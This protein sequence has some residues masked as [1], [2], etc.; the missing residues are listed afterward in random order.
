M[1][2]I[3]IRVIS[4][5]CQDLGPSILYL[6]LPVVLSALFYSHLASFHQLGYWNFREGQF[7]GKVFLV[8]PP[9]HPLPMEDVWGCSSV[10]SFVK[11]HPQT[12]FDLIGT[13]LVQDPSNSGQTSDDT[14]LK[15]RKEKVE[16]EKL[17]SFRQ[18]SES[19]SPFSVFSPQKERLVKKRLVPTANGC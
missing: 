15:K 6:F 13:S 3:A 11:K 10:L 16:V 5:F 18:K 8:N 9:I 4:L 12:D 1:V 17:G 19:V 7:N 14:L 2:G